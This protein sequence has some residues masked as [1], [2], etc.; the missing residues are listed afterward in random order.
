MTL[1]NAY[2]NSYCYQPIHIYEGSG[3]LVTT[4]LRPGRRPTGKEAVAILK[5]VVE[6]I[7]EAWPEAGILLRADAHYGNGAV[8]DYCEG[9]D[10]HY[11]LGLTPNPRLTDEARPWTEEAVR[12]ARLSTVRL[13]EEFSYRA[14][15]WKRPRRRWTRSSG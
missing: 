14:R 5:R 13:F 10:V 15:G 2:Y 12:Q 1:F 8:M 7:R 11:I 9:N 3:R 4:V 6:R